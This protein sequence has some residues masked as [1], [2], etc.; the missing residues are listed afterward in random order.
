RRGRAVRRAAAA[1]RE[2]LS[3]V[4][5]EARG[6]AGSLGAEPGRHGPLARPRGQRRAP[7]A[8]RPMTV[9]SR[10]TGDALMVFAS[11]VVK[12]L[13]ATVGVAHTVAASLV[14]ADRRGVHT[15]GVVRLPSY[16]DEAR[17]GRIAITATPVLERDNGP[18]ATIDGGG[19]FGA[20]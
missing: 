18:V 20:V 19:G 15:H 14:E 7:P 1:V 4:R 12:G 10:F 9:S 13:G 11:E 16:C 17:A 5:S 8:H 2:R 3:A 6:L